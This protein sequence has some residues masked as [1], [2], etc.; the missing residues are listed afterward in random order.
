MRS[1]LAAVTLAAVAVTALAPVRA[2][3]ADENDLREFRVG[4]EVGELPRS[5][6]LGLACADSP[7]HQE[8]TVSV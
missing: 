5:G 4:M 8:A 3:R 2:A 6:Y 1:A 7:E